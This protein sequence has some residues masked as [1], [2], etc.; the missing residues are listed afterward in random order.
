[1]QSDQWP[2]GG[3]K[4]KSNWGSRAARKVL[5]RERFI[6]DLVNAGRNQAS[7]EPDGGQDGN[8]QKKRSSRRR[9]SQAVVHVIF[10]A[11]VSPLIIYVN[12]RA[13]SKNSRALTGLSAKTHVKCRVVSKNSREMQGC[14]Q[15]LT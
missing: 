5:V 4:E 10:Y 11:V 6:N 9:S 3:M 14:Q 7:S 1:V 8:K 15:K 13:V 2:V 12:S